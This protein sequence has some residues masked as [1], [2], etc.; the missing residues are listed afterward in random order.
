MSWASVRSK[1][2]HDWQLGGFLVG[3]AEGRGAIQALL[4]LIQAGSEKGSGA[5]GGAAAE[6][7]DYEEGGAD[8]RP[9]RK[10]KK[11]AQPLC[12]PLIA[13]CNDLY[14]PALRPLRAIAKI[15]NYKKPTVPHPLPLSAPPWPT[16][17]TG[18]DLMLCQLHLQSIEV[19]CVGL[20]LQM[21]RLSS[22]LRYICSSEGLSID[23]PV[24]PG[25]GFASICMSPGM[26]E[27]VLHCALLMFFEPFQI[28][29]CTC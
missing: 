9:K 14:A 18:E 29:L 3:G 28:F 26:T 24:R 27:C 13:I 10:G 19:V 16:C 22:R 25:L 21:D 6:D 17:A 20:I 4:K 15:V 2:G 5:G 12:R 1:D 23:R 7:H 8:G 11:R